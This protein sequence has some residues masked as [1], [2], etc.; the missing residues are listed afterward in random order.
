MSCKVISALELV[1][2]I[3]AAFPRLRDSTLISPFLPAGA[4]CV[5]SGQG[6]NFHPANISATLHKVSSAVG[7][8]CTCIHA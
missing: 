5:I 3:T 2:E 6:A 1:R 8:L 4:S 7:L